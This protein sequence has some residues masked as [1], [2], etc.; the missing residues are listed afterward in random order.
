MS[1]HKPPSP[2]SEV[3]IPAVGSIAD[4]T[5][6]SGGKEYASFD[7]TTDEGAR[8]YL[9]A[10]MMPLPSIKSKVKEVIDLVHI[11]AHNVTSQPDEQGE[12]KEFQRTVI[13]DDKGQGYDCGSIG[14]AKSIGIISRIRG[15]PP[16]DPPVK[17]TVTLQELDGK[18]QWL[19]LVPDITSLLTR[20][21]LSPSKKATG[22]DV[23]NPG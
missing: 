13:F 12:V 16:F 21:K 9:R 11:F 6:Q 2:S 5:M 15:M 8:M 14:V 7:V 20:N 10:T 23:P 17:V 1:E 18:K 3:A 4:L 19:T 22:N